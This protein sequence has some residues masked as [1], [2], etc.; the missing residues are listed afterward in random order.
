MTTRWLRDATR[1][2]PRALATVAVFASAGC[3]GSGSSDAGTELLARDGELER[4]LRREIAAD[5]VLSME[6]AR[7][8]IVASNGMLELRGVVPSLRAREHLLRIAAGAD[9]AGILDGLEVDPSSTSGEPDV[10]TNIV[11]AIGRSL[12]FGEAILG[13][14]DLEVASPEGIVTLRG[15]VRDAHLRQQVE[16][17]AGNT[18]GVVVVVDDLELRN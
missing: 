14:G 7:V 2:L 12:H 11:D 13:D 9:A 8:R 10:D 4:S 18:P 5:S 15:S 1:T 3:S 16:T 6:S 17:I